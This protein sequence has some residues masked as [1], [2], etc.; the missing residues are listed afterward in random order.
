MEID[1]A[2]NK[3]YNED[4][5]KTMAKMPNEFIDLTITNPPCDERVFD[6]TKVGKELFRVT[7]RGGVVVW[8]VADQTKN[9][10]ESLFSFKQAIYFV[11]ECGFN[12]LDTM[13]YHKSKYPPIYPYSLGRYSDAFEYMFV[14]SKGEHKTFNPIVIEKTPKSYTKKGILYRKA[15]DSTIYRKI[16]IDK[17]I[18]D[19]SN[20]W[21]A[22]TTENEDTKDDLMIFPPQLV[23]DHIVSWSNRGDI[24]Y[25]PF[26]GRGTTAMMAILN[27]R[28]FIGSEISKTYCY[29]ANERI[30]TL[31]KQIQ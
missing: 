5:L 21:T 6:F 25:D 13:I 17:K 30:N 10:C 31:R 29:I 19:L 18:K 4:C 24:V 9:F 2:L 7:K 20:V 23:Y 16:F 8:I 22:I 15:D 3:I 1:I 26:M 14:F 11:E 27:S 12:L 28:K